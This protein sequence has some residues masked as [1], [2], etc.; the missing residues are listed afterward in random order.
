MLSQVDELVDDGLAS[1]WHHGINNCALDRSSQIMSSLLPTSNY[2]SAYA[3]R[4]H[5]MVMF[6]VLLADSFTKG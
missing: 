2:T 4:R 3:W 6:S 5:A 1:V